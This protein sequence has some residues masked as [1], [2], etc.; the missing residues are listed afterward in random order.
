MKLWQFFLL[1]A[2]LWLIAMLAAY[3][4]NL[5][6]LPE[7]GIG[8]QITVPLPLLQENS[9]IITPLA[10]PPPPS[11]YDVYGT[12]AGGAV[13]ITPMESDDPDISHWILIVTRSGF[14]SFQEFDTQTKCG[15]AA[16]IVLK[17]SPTS[18]STKAEC[19]PK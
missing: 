5:K 3:G 14:T 8:G 2:V 19:T 11:Y 15:I 13:G 6:P 10:P 16:G 17:N 18:D 4:Q 9:A 12:G 7:T 1:A